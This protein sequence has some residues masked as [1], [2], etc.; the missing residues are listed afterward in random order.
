MTVDELKSFAKSKGIILPPLQSKKYFTSIIS[1]LKE[2]EELLFF[3]K[4]KKEKQMVL[5]Y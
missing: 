4:L 1:E 3:V 5:S 2:D